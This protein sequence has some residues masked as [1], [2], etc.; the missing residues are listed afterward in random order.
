[1]SANGDLP[2]ELPGG[3]LCGAVRFTVTERPLGVVNCHCSQCRRFHGH[4]GAY[5]TVPRASVRF[6][7]DAT[8]TWYRSSAKAQRGF[9][10][11]CGSSLFWQG[12]GEA[13]VDVAAG[14]LDQPTGLATVRHI[15]VASK[16]D[17]YEITDSLEQFPES[18][19]EPP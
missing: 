5:I 10:G 3:C 7:G 9:C 11:T 14:S 1:M 18:A 13:L 2:G 6:D 4:F 19:P 12:D 15:Q 8:L 16:P 17:Y